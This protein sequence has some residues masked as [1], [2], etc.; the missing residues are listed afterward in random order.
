MLDDGVENGICAV[1]GFVLM[2]TGM[3]GWRPAKAGCDNDGDH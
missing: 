1:Q 2:T 3:S